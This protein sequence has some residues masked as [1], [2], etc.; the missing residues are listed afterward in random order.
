[1]GIAW[2]KEQEGYLKWKG[3][4]RQRRMVDTGAIQRAEGIGRRAGAAPWPYLS[5]S[6]PEL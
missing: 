2:N 1:M 6:D 4:Q 3:M 5:D